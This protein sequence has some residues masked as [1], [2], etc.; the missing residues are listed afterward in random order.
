MSIGFIFITWLL[1]AVIFLAK[2]SPARELAAKLSREPVPIRIVTVLVLGVALIHGSTKTN[3]QNN[4]SSSGRGTSSVSGMPAWWQGDDTDTDGDGI[5]DLWEKWTHGN[6]YV[7]DSHLDRD[8]DGLTDLEEF[9]YQ[10]DPRTADTDGDGLSDYI[11]VIHGMDPLI[12]AD[13]TPVEPDID[14]NG[15]IDLW[16]GSLYHYDFIDADNNGFDDRYE[17]YNMPPATDSNFD[18]V[19]HVYTSRSAAL[20]WTNSFGESGIVLMATTGTDVKLRLPFGEDT[21]L[22]LLPAPE[23]ID[24]PAGQLWKSSMH[25]SFVPREGQ[26]LN[27]NALISYDGAIAHKVTDCDSIVEIFPSATPEG[28]F[29]PLAAAGSGGEGRPDIKIV[30]IRM[31][32]EPEN[33]AWHFDTE[34]IGPFAITNHAGTLLYSVQW[35][36]DDLDIHSPYSH[37]M[38]VSVKP[39]T[40]LNKDT[41]ILTAV[42]ELDDSTYITNRT[43]IRKC[44]KQ[45]F[46]IENATR[47]FS[48]HLEETAT[49]QLNIYGCPHFHEEGWLEGEIMR[50]ATD[51]WQ[52]VGWI[53]MDTNEA[54][55]QKRI[56]V[57]SLQHTVVW[58]GI[59]TEN[60][61]LVESPDVFTAG[62]E[63]FKRILPTVVSGEP[64]PPPYYTVFF[65]FR[66]DNSDQSQI[67]DEASTRIY[68]PQVVKIEMTAAA[69]QEF[70]EPLLYPETVYPHLLGRTDNIVGCESN[71]ILYAG[72]STITLS[73]LLDSIVAKCQSFVPLNVNL[74]FTHSP[75]K[76]RHK[77]V[78]AVIVEDILIDRKYTLG[79]TPIEHVSWRNEKPQGECF[80]YVDKFRHHVCEDRYRAENNVAAPKDYDSD[81]FP[82]MLDEFANAIASV[83]IHE[84]GHTLGLVHDNLF[85][86]RSMHN[87]TTN[88]N[89]WIMNRSS[90]F[91]QHFGKPGAIENSWSTR[92]HM[93]LQ[94][95]LPK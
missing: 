62:R 40:T 44:T 93:Y 90:S 49:F 22:R 45:S 76:G 53:D 84:T 91:M 6:P 58:D 59:A 4:A 86:T 5:P 17:F 57:S 29:S 77:R 60:A 95:I 74:K 11:E 63:P 16:Q 80:F 68:V 31:G 2:I 43:F 1:L 36:S 89:G 3:S 39:G 26:D 92:N 9:H 72:C 88:K 25:V 87:S 10:T 41:I 54:G 61:A 27:G 78:H 66:K 65:R 30:Y 18:V 46:G 82:F 83:S 42:S 20:T 35:S 8:G 56:Y 13:F 21:Q 55:H 23:G 12:P 50:L 47:N 94:F 28:G 37:M 81:L 15:I 70:K 52:H 75:V 7:A 48:P 19:V 79:F 33:A 67:L 51:G 71:V 14:N 69:Y 38:L 24:P 64:V 32:I 34:S 73:Q 85:G